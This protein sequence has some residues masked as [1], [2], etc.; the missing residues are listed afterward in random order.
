[1][2]NVIFTVGIVFMYNIDFINAIFECAI[3]FYNSMSE[4]FL[5]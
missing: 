2:I 3:L 5:L 1:M 4:K